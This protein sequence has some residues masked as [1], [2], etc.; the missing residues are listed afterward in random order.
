MSAYDVKSNQSDRAYVDRTLKYAAVICT[1]VFVTGYVFIPSPVPPLASAS[2]RLMYTLRLQAPALWLISAMAG[3]VAL[4]R[5][6]TSAINPLDAESH[7][8]VEVDNNV[9]RNTVEQFL[10]NAGLQ[11]IL[12]TYL[13]HG[14]MHV[15]PTL[16][17]LFWL[18]RVLFW[19]G[20]RRSPIDGAWVYLGMGITVF[21]TMALCVVTAVCMVVHGT[22]GL[23]K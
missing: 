4:K 1:V 11:M 14:T 12:S 2:E 7:H 16:A 6:T 15:I 3:A 13:T 17:V 5:R 20:Y 8:L 22:E 19:A 10:T 21:P 18:G 9:L 23:G